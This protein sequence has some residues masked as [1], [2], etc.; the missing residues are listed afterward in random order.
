M[1][2]APKP[3]TVR[4]VTDS[5]ATIPRALA[6]ELA[7]DVV[8][9]WLR[10]GEQSYRD[11]I[12]LPSSDFYSK[13]EQKD[14]AVSTSGPSTVDYHDAFENALKQAACV[15]CVSVASFVSATFTSASIAAREFG[16]RV[17]VIDSAS[18][19]MGEGFVVIEAAR[20]A[21]RGC[22]LEEVTRIATQTVSRTQLVA[23][24]NTFEYLRRGGR[25]NAVLAYA[26]AALNIKPVFAFRGGK[27]EQLG[28]PRSRSKA[29]ERL[30]EE[31]RAAKPARLAVAHANVEREARALLDRLTDELGPQEAYLTEF[32]PLMGAHTGPG[33]LAVA[34][35]Q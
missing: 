1:P 19:S 29:I 15:A 4:V 18:A 35:T 3:V 13:L 23:T 16:E 7:I 28:R 25:V 17:T 27:I 10:F 11:G 24:I 5:A 6:S 31:V 30:V 8:P 32:T 2:E 20:A 21:K 22:S 26:G 14:V 9:M 34:F 33:L 12:D